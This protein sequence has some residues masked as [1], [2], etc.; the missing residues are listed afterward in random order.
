VEYMDAVNPKRVDFVHGDGSH[1]EKRLQHK[2]V[3]R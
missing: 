3:G 1:L 2:L